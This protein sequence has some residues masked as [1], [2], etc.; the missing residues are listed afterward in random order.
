M[1]IWKNQRKRPQLV[2]IIYLQCVVVGVGLAAP[3][4]LKIR[5]D[6]KKHFRDLEIVQFRIE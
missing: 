4:S 1:C 3:S 5:K 2:I 6:E